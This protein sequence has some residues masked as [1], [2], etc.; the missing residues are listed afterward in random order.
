MVDYDFFIYF[1]ESFFTCRL[2]N[3][4]LINTIMKCVH[5]SMFCLPQGVKRGRYKNMILK[6]TPVL[7]KV[8]LIKG[9]SFEARVH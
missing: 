4:A 3:A 8:N 1:A 9:L 6:V 7:T 2:L 5:R